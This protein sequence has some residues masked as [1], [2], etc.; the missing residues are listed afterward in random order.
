MDILLLVTNGF[1][2]KILCAVLGL[3]VVY[4]YNHDY[5]FSFIYF[6]RYIDIFL[7]RFNMF[8]SHKEL[9]LLSSIDKVYT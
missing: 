9:I 3:K 6:D 7:I 2:D 5:T 4:N 1:C 8:M